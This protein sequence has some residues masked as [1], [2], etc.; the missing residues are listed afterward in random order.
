M[1]LAA[2]TL[3]SG[4]VLSRYRIA[5]KLGQGGMGEVYKAVDLELDS[6]VALKLL[7]PW[8]ASDPSNKKHLLREARLARSINH[9]NIVTI[10]SIDRAD[11]LDFIVME[12]VEGETLSDLLQDGP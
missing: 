2:H 5:Q 10:Y 3:R 7:P 11:D 4:T 6:P 8:A 12:F 1:G 9:P